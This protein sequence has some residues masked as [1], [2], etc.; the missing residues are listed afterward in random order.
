MSAF[1]SRILRVSSV[2]IAAV[3][4]T[5]AFSAPASATSWYGAYTLKSKATGRCLDSNYSGDTYALPCNGGKY[6]SW[7][8]D[9]E[10]A[11]NLGFEDS[12]TTLCLVADGY[13]G[14]LVSTS[15]GPCATTLGSWIGIQNSDGTWTFKSF[16]SGTLCL[17][18]NTNGNGN[19]VGAV[20]ADTCNGGNY[21][22]FYVTPSGY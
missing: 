3:A 20:Y 22:H 11:S 7:F 10:S 21:Q 14:S 18:S 6:Q 9:S 1:K 12:Q 19:N 4:L 15:T 8:L 17:D 5:A 2:A 13:T 16:L